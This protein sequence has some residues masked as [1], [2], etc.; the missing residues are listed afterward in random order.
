M[1]DRPSAEYIALIA[2]LIA[3][4]ALGTDIMLPALAQIGMD[5]NAPS[6][7]DV[8]YIVT[9][10]FLGMAVGQIFV[11]PLSD[12]VGRKPVIYG[13]Y[14]VFVAGCLVSIF[15]GTWEAMLAGRMLQGLG[16]STPRIVTVAL[17]RDQ[18]AGAPMARVMSIVMAAFIAVPILAPMLGQVLVTLG[19][20]QA[21]FVGLI[22]LAIAVSLWCA[23]RL[24]ETLAPEAR[25]TFRAAP[26]LAGLR[27]VLR[28]RPVMGYTLATALN[29]GMFLGYLGS[30][31]QIFAEVF[32]RGAS[33]VLYF[34]LAA[35]SIGVA[36]LINARLVERLGMA[37]LTWAAQ[38]G[39]AG[40]SIVFLAVLIPYAG[41]PPFWS[42]VAWQLA[43][44]FCVGVL[45]GNLNA[46][47]LEPLG[48]MPG[49]GAAF[50]GALSMLLSL[51]LAAH[52]S[53]A[54]DGTV[55]PLVAGFAG[56]SATALPVLR[57]A[58][59]R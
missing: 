23:V 44:F 53:G 29:F 15:G 45:F 21:C 3:I 50:T 43:A 22:V 6:A 41:V 59:R 30:A 32:G 24:P 34:A 27:E 5:L 55:W 33:F 49:L 25:R 10:F 12:A 37:R 19:D 35:A 46:L 2:A 18:Y 51:P 40:V 14:I 39:A 57:W 52:I 13:G 4:G 38:V 31:Q 17:V 26:L 58:A 16:A 11:G 56:L 1:T 42:F 8:H 36:A 7:N 9:A 48:H 20:W 54:F 47:A 28:S